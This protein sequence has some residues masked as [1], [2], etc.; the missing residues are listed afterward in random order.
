MKPGQLLKEG[1]VVRHDNRG[2]WVG[3]EAGSNEKLPAGH[4]EHTFGARRVF[5]SN[6]QAPIPPA[7]LHPRKG[8]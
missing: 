7:A 8:R 6:D 3:R 2:V 5:L 1:V 4:T